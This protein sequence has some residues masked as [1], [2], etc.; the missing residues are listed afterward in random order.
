MHGEG[1][2][3][4]KEELHG[5]ELYEEGELQRWELAYMGERGEGEREGGAEE[6]EQDAGE[7]DRERDEGVRDTREGVTAVTGERA[8]WG[9]VGGR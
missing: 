2:L 8:G 5:E 4:R 1:E 3:H 9:K 7:W 6:R